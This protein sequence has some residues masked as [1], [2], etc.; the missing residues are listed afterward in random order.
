MFDFFPNNQQPPSG[1][2]GLD[3]Q[4]RNAAFIQSVRP[5]PATDSDP[6]RFDYEGYFGCDSHGDLQIF[7]NV[8]ICT[9]SEDNE[10]ISITNM[11][12]H[13]ATR[14]CYQYRIDPHQL[15]WIEHYPQR[16]YRDEIPAS[17][18]LVTFDR[19]RDGDGHIHFAKPKWHHFGKEKVEELIQTTL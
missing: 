4:R 19:A 15:T 6:F 7:G 3:D 1:P 18:D 11:V 16:G 14:V 12:E 13:L 8:V 9:E 17:Y 2:F 10:G 5:Q